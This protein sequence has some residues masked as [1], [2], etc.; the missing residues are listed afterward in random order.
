MTTI[1]AE[2]R[3]RP[4]RIGF[5]VN[6][7]DMASVR[8]TM[9][10]CTCL[11]GGVYNPII[12]VCTTLPDA[13]KAFPFQA[14]SGPALANGY[15]D[16]FEPDVFVEPEPGLTNGLSIAPAAISFSQSRVAPLGAYLDGTIDDHERLPPGLSVS[17]L[18]KALGSAAK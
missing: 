7:V 4:T 13:W 3:L 14:L 18:Y 8:H 12:P 10:V 6:P 9:R 2:L 15:I 1:S 16:F 5:L 11:W 17:G